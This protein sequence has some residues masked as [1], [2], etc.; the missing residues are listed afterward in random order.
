MHIWEFSILLL[1]VISIVILI[2]LLQTTIYF[3]RTTKRIVFILEQLWET[4]L[5]TLGGKKNFLVGKLSVFQHLVTLIEEIWWKTLDKGEP[6]HSFLG[7]DY[8]ENCVRL[9]ELYADR[10]LCNSHLL[11]KFTKM[12]SDA[13]AE[14]IKNDV[15]HWGES[16]FK[17]FGNYPGPDEKR[18]KQFT[19]DQVSVFLGLTEGK[20]YRSTYRQMMCPFEQSMLKRFAEEWQKNWVLQNFNE[21]K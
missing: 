9:G 14:F 3:L 16:S 12:D 7:F 17:G 1:L 6:G 15:K 20:D 13:Y 4:E 11:E 8:A 19:E 2:Y 5:R 10:I 18:K 21:S